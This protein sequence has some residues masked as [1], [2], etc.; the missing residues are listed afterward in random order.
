MADMIEWELPAIIGAL[1]AVV[2][3]GVYVVNTRSIAEEN[4]DRIKNGL[5]GID[6]RLD[7]IESI[8]D[9]KFTALWN[10]MNGK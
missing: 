5:D 3:V 2:P 6:K 9:N 7:R 10:R 1:A 4:R 8:L